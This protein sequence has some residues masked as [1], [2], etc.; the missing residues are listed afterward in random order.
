MAAEALLAP[1]SSVPALYGDAGSA[2]SAGN[3]HIASGLATLVTG[4]VTITLTGAS[5]F[6]DTNYV[7]MAT[8]N[9]A[10][11]GAIDA[12]NSLGATIV[13][14]SSF[15]IQSTD[16]ADVSTIFWTAIGF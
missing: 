3:N 9:G 16:P 12:A 6:S 11:S 5:A 10:P 14:G 8:F 2:A 13:T 15:T 1:I 4:T 7:V